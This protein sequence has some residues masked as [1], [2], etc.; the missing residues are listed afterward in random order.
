[1]II[2]LLSKALV[3]TIVRN[4]TMFALLNAVLALST[5]QVAAK[6]EFHYAAAACKADAKGHLYVA[7][8]EYV[9]AVPFLK[10]GIYMVDRGPPK[11]RRL[12]PDPA[13]PEGCPG[14]PSQQRS[15]AFYF[16]S[17]LTDSKDGGA[18]ST[19]R[20]APARLTLFEVWNPD[21]KADR[22]RSEWYGE[23]S[24]ALYAE[25]ACAQPTIRE[26]L[27]NGLTACRNRQITERPVE[28]WAAAYISD[29]NTYATPLG[30]P[31]IVVCGPNL[32]TGP[33]ISK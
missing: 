22:E 30:R 5:P 3:N 11:T 2:S 15:Y 27:P 31:F 19:R 18:K 28:D 16:G 10:N 24:R 14:N 29:P 7:L 25:T 8:G 9:L 32:H 33:A 6:D 20:E 4:G 17:P 21:P 23:S 1:V 13:E 12:A 26:A